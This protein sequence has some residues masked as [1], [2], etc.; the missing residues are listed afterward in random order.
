[1]PLR[2][3]GEVV[4]SASSSP[5]G[6]DVLNDILHGRFAVALTVRQ[7]IQFVL[8]AKSACTKN[9][10]AFVGSPSCCDPGSLLR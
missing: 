1:M 6:Y 10:E 8:M 3:G 9:N 2:L 7:M 4:V 5:Q